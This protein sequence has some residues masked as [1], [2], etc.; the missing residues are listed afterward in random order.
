MS[1]QKTLDGKTDC[2]KSKHTGSCVVRYSGNNKAIE[3]GLKAVHE[4]YPCIKMTVNGKKQKE[5]PKD[6]SKS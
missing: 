1:D 3:E 5:T 6:W 2:K 4:K